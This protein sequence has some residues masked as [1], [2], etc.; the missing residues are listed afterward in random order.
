MAEGQD[1]LWID[2]TVPDAGTLKDFYAGVLGRTVTPFAMDGYDDYCIDRSDGKPLAGV[3]H[4]RGPNA[5]LPP[6]WLVY[7]PVADLAAA[8][9]QCADQGGAVVAGPK[10]MDGQ[11]RFAVIRDP[12]GAMCALLESQGG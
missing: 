9:A 2:L 3:C 4:A 11:H 8:L 1:T 6:V 12:A 10:D 7:F 5:D